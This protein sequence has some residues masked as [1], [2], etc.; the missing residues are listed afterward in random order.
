MVREVIIDEREISQILRMR[1]NFAAQF[2]QLFKRSFKLSTAFS[3]APSSCGVGSKDMPTSKCTATMLHLDHLKSIHKDFTSCGLNIVIEWMYGKE[4]KFSS[5]KLTEALAAAFAL[6]LYGMVDAIEQAVWTYC[7]DLSALTVFLHHFESYTS[8]M[9]QKLLRKS[10]D[11]LEE[12]CEMTSFRNLSLPIF[13]KVVEKAI[14]KMKDSE[15]GPFGVIKAIALWESKN[16]SYNISTSLL[17]KLSFDSL[18]NAEMNRLVEMARKLGLKKLAE[19]ILRQYRTL[20]TSHVI[21]G[22]LCEDD[23]IKICAADADQNVARRKVSAVKTFTETRLNEDESE[24]E[25]K[26][27]HLVVVIA[28]EPTPLD[29]GALENAVDSLKEPINFG[30]VPLDKSVNNLNIESST[31]KANGFTSSVEDQKC[32]KEQT[33][34]QLG[35]QLFNV[36]AL[37]ALEVKL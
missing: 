10:T 1:Q 26:R 15:C 25:R 12:I 20:K 28:S 29:E 2:V 19:Y 8:E 14:N 23:S 13:K 34:T 27:V 35:S 6:E 7:K 24:Y 4:V 18:S 32:H 21:R 31:T 16:C 36:I 37:N 30:V 33:T 22:L 5:D 17:R 9:K 11:A 3:R